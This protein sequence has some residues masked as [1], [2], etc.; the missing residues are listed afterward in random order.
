M[1][2]EHEATLPDAAAARR[3]KGII[4]TA[5]AAAAVIVILLLPCV[6]AAATNTIYPRTSVAGVQVGGM[7]RSE[8]LDVLSA[9]LPEALSSRRR[10]R[11]RCFRAVFVQSGAHRLSGPGC[12]CRL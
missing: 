3:R 1:K 9:Q 10:K 7:S 5:I 4:I 2:K 12:G 11:R 8:A 6:L